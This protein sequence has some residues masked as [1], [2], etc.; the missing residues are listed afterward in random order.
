MEQDDLKRDYWR[1]RILE[2]GSVDWAQS[3]FML[4]FLEK[5]DSLRKKG[6]RLS[7]QGPD[8]KAAYFELAKADYRRDSTT[9]V[10]DFNAS[11]FR[12]AR[13]VTIQL[14]RCANGRIKF[15]WLVKKPMGM[16]FTQELRGRLIRCE[17]SADQPSPMIDLS[18]IETKCGLIGEEVD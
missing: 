3:Q 6:D 11:S 4:E 13:Y 17:E 7:A 18:E 10:I 9:L 14:V 15:K 8:D 5:G 1:L 16:S 12:I 2:D